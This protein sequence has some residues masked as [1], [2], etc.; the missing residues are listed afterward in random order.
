MLQHDLEETLCEEAL[1]WA[2]VAAV[3]RADWLDRAHLDAVLAGCTPGPP[4][5]PTQRQRQR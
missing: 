4:A 2:V 3:R 1:L 5:A